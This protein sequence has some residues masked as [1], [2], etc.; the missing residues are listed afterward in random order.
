[1]VGNAGAGGVELP[2]EVVGVELLVVVVVVVVVAVVLL[3]LLLEVVPLL[4]C[5]QATP[6]SSQHCHLRSSDQDEKSSSLSDT[7][8]SGGAVGVVLVL[9]PPAFRNKVVSVGG[10]PCCS[11]KQHHAC[12]PSD[13][14]S[15]SRVLQLNGFFGGGTQPRWKC[16][17]HHS[18]FR[19]DQLVFHLERSTEQSKEMALPC[20]PVLPESS[21]SISVA[22]ANEI[23]SSVTAI[24]E[25]VLVC[26]TTNA[27]PP[28]PR[29][30]CAQQ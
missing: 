12:F 3:L 17:Q 11:K 13:Q 22:L 30:S 2:V 8:Q 5:M 28:H 26:V 19:I 25:L 15:T 23:P 16:S 24:G 6:C 9:L 1:M 7:V 27:T 4:G 21:M 20:F 14:I 18:C 10:H 29:S